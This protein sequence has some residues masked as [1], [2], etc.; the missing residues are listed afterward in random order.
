[1]TDL[2][3]D[4]VGKI[5]SLPIS[6]RLR[7]I[8]L[9]AG[10]LAGVDTIRVTSGGQMPLATALAKGAKKISGSRWRLPNGKIVRIGSTRHDDGGAADLRLELNGAQ[11]KFTTS[12]GQKLFAD[13]AEKCAALG[14]SGLG[15]GVPYMGNRT[16][17]VGFGTKAVWSKKPHP[18]PCWLVNAVSRGWN[19]PINLNAISPAP[20]IDVTG[21]GRYR[22]V[23]RPHLFLR[24]GA[25][26]AFKKIGQITDGTEVNVV[27]RSGDWA[28]IDL[29]FDGTPDG[30]SHGAYLRKV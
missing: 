26:T 18:V 6:A 22:V 20:G 28:K 14:C 2:I 27:D 17:H 24:A 3:E 25:G 12:S 19:N 23:A 7:R 10:E 21:T 4:T 1:M 30:F 11:Q 15:A 5:R 9:A 13:F 8:L 29:L 16:I